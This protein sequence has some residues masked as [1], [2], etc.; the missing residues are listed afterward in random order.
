MQYQPEIL[1]ESERHWRAFYGFCTFLQ[2][3]VK[4]K[5]NHG[6]LS[7]RETMKL[8]QSKAPL[9]QVVVVIDDIAIGTNIVTVVDRTHHVVVISRYRESQKSKLEKG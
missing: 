8:V 3:H 9:V 5:G 6:C 7:I 4:I 2:V 1:G